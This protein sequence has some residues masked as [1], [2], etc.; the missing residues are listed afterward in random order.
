MARSNG[1]LINV[2]LLEMANDEFADL[3][4]HPDHYEDVQQELV[5]VEWAM[6]GTAPE[7]KEEAARLSLA[8]LAYELGVRLEKPADPRPVFPPPDEFAPSTLVRE[9]DQ[10]LA[11]ER[12][13]A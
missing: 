3:V 2:R 6:Q 1:Y 5:L 11:V 4:K 8:W 9:I 10:V 13:A 12:A 7:D